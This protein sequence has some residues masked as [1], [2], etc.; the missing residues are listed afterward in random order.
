MTF[1]FNPLDVQLHVWNLLTY[2][3]FIFEY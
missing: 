1:F 2:N 3:L